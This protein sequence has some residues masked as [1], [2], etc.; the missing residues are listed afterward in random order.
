M[1]HPAALT[2]EDKNKAIQAGPPT[3]DA[4]TTRVAEAATRKAL[5]WAAAQMNREDAMEFK[6][7]LRAAGVEPWED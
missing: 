2:E 3:F 5:W 7:G 6:Q 1:E 4:W